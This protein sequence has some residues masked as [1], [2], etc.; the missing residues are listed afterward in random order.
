MSDA[1]RGTGSSGT[2]MIRDL[3]NGVNAANVEFWLNSNN[4]STWS[5]HIPWG[6]TI[7]GSTGSSTFYY[8][9]GSGWQRLGVW[10]VSAAQTVHFRLGATGTSGFG[11]PTDFSVNITRGTVPPQTSPVRYLSVG[12]TSVIAA[13][14][15]HGTGGAPFIQW[16]LAWSRDPNVI[17]QDGNMSSSG[18]STVNGLLPG[19]KYYFWARGE[20]TLGWGPW[21]ARTDVTTQNVPDAPS[22]PVIS[23]IQ[24]TSVDVSWT[25]NGDGG[26]AINGFQL[27]K[28]TVNDINTATS[29]SATSPKTVTGLVPGTTYFFWVRASNTW[30]WGP[31]SAAGTNQ[32][33]AGARMKVGGVWKIA[34]PYVRS[35]GVW[36]LAIPLVKS[37]GEWR[38]TT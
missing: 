5:D 37:A 7:N 30:G 31:W 28:N 18:T 12:N 10:F 34:V 21:S 19:T 8:H 2:M 35:G 23:N 25:P 36:K 1:T 4:S 3:G 13:F 17:A 33:I 29:S 15:G 27:A 24:P 6:W 9:P 14:D 20:N 22:T 38:G 11:G 16:Q 32:T 26:A